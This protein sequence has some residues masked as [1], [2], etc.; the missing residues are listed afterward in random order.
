MLSLDAPPLCFLDLYS[1]V[2]SFSTLNKYQPCTFYPLIYFFP[3]SHA[4]RSSQR[5]FPPCS[6]VVFFL[7]ACSRRPLQRSHRTVVGPA[8]E[9]PSFVLGLCSCFS[10]T[11]RSGQSRRKPPP[12]PAFSLCSVLYLTPLCPHHITTRAEQEGELASSSLSTLLHSK[13]D[14]RKGGLL[15]QIFVEASGRCCSLAHTVANLFLW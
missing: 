7:R 3:C 10:R 11:D 13:R 14:K 5:S 12:P 15:Y 2:L 4:H 1:L 8:S 9:R 6:L